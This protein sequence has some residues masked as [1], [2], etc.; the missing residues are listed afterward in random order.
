MFCTLFYSCI[1][2]Y[3]F[4]YSFFWGGT[5]SYVC[6][7]MCTLPLVEG[8]FTSSLNLW[9]TAYINLKNQLTEKEAEL[10]RMHEEHVRGI[11]V[12][13]RATWISE[14]EK[15]SRYF[16]NLEKRNFDKKHIQKLRKGETTI[17]EPRDIITEEKRFYETLYTS[18]DIEDDKI[19]KVLNDL[20]ITPINQD[21]AM[22]SEGHILKS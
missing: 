22:L 20:N 15:N 6:L 14:G 21:V 12:R 13:T 18:N 3:L 17:T 7:P 1:V 16:L 5:L 9:V 2:I 19:L 8:N 11:L 4:I 10:Q